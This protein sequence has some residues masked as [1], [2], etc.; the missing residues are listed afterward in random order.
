MDDGLELEFLGDR[1]LLFGAAGDEGQR[2]ER[3]ECDHGADQSLDLAAH[4]DPVCPA[5]LATA[6]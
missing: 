2:H 1:E 4:R 6:G 3:A 5:G